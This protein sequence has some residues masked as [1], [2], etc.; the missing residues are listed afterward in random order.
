MININD[1]L[2]QLSQERPVFHSEADFQHALAWLIHLQEPHACIR[3]EYRPLPG[4][5]YLDVWIQNDQGAL[6][7][8]LKYATRRLE[9]DHA[10]EHFALKNRAAQDITRYD[11]V[12]DIGRLERIV[13]VRPGVTGYAILL[14]ND[15]IYWTRSTRERTMDAAFRLQE[16][17]SLNGSLG[18]SVQAAKGTIVKRE[19][20]LHL[21][22]SYLMSWHDY[23]TV[24]SHATGGHFRF[25]AVPVYG[26]TVSHRS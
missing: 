6:A 22:G 19:A 14:T 12:K 16:G 8:E 3:L 25:L 2:A 13:A 21:R 20:A 24:G 18:W 4:P 11:F 23:S 7:I 17:A 26:S 9:V 15:S 10:G 1:A 5:L